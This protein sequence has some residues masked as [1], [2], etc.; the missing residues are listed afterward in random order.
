MHQLSDDL[1][2]IFDVTD[3]GELTMIVGIEIMHRKVSVTISQGQYV[4]SILKRHG[5][6]NANPVLTPM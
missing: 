6:E 3:L 1:K 2:A 5:M 4:D